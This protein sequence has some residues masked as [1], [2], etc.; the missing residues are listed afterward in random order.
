M[1]ELPHQAPAGRVKFW[2]MPVRQIA[3]VHSESATFL[4]DTNCG[5]QFGSRLVKS[6][7]K[8]LRW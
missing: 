7:E 5:L 3:S 1:R 4:R 2:R 6:V 8:G